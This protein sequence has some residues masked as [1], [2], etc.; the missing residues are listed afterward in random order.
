LV[1]DNDDDALLIRR[2]LEGK[3]A[4]RVYH[5]RD[6]WEGL[7]QARQK[8]PDLIVTDLTMP[9][10]DGFGLVEE[11]KLDPRTKDIPI[12]VVSA[13]DIT[14]EERKRLNGNIEAVY[15]KGS[16]PPRKFV[17]QVVQVI[18]EEKGSDKGGQ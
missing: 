4:Y 14:P 5:A 16:L 18:E 9:G 1:D 17:E 10:M 15:Q 7:S 11:L 3:K 2:L 13:K 6:G 12:V 8:R